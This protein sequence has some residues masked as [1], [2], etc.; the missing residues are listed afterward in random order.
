M[1]GQLQMDFILFNYIYNIM[2]EIQF[3]VS[4]IAENVRRYALLW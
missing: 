4:P 2:A 3:Y 1:G